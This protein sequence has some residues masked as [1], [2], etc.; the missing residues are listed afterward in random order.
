M[1]KSTVIKC[2]V[3]VA[4]L[5]VAAFAVLALSSC[6]HTHSYT[7]MSVI[8]EPTCGETGVQRA[9]C[10]C[11][12]YQ[13]VAI[14]KLSHSEGA[15]ETVYP[16]TCITKGSRKLSCKSCGDIMKSEV[17]PALGHDLVEYP[18]K[19]STCAEVGHKAYSACTR[20]DHTTYKEVAKLAHTPGADPTCTEPQLCTV[21]EGI[22]NPAKGHLEVVTTGTPALC[23]KVGTTDSIFCLTC[24][25][26]LQEQSEVP[27]R[28]HNLVELPYLAPTCT[29][30]G[31]TKGL[32]CKD[33]G[34]N[35]MEQAVI[36]KAAHTY[37]GGT[38]DSEC[39]V[40]GFVRRVGLNK[41]N[42]KNDETIPPYSASC[43]TFGVTKGKKCLD[44]GE[45]LIEQEISGVKNPTTGAIETPAH[46]EDVLPAVPA[47]LTKPGL[48]EGKYCT[49]CRMI[50]KQQEV[51]PALSRKVD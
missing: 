45:I 3:L 2:L 9:A 11:G 14:P 44:C 19:A 49:V 16:A 21:C 43:T 28:E 38:S 47:T 10:E 25:I 35:V 6:S 42:H 48:T 39:D 26:T 41:C 37:S 29:A 46:T 4:L 5:A 13:V 8:Q 1:K 33:C 36:A 50:T 40:C 20:C 7:R 18:E 27:K 31:R 30:T 15:W 23:N 17:I 51:V 12:D 22:V 34:A 24:N 32:V